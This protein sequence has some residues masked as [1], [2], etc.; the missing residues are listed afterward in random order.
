MAEK[1]TVVRGIYQNAEHANGIIPNLLAAGFSKE[2]VSI[3]RSANEDTI[4]PGLNGTGFTTGGVVVSIHCD[5][6]D[7]ITLAKD[8]LE[9]TD[10]RDVSSNDEVDKV[11]VES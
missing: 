9:K 2:A 11:F 7:Q 3:S 5:T 8:V 4:A 1:K 10:A 6:T